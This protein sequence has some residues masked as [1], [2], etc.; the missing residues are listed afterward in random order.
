MEKTVP[1]DEG[2]EAFVEVLNANGVEYIFLNPGTDTFPIQEAL[3]EFKALGK[4]TPEVILCLHESVA[5]A[6]A[7]GY[8]MVTGRP[9]VV[10]IHVDIG[11]LQIGGE[12]HNAQRG[13]IGVVICAG[14]APSTIE[15]NIRGGR[16]MGIHWTQEQ[17]D[18]AGIV[19]G[20]VKWEYELRSNASIHQ[21][22][23]RAFQ[24]A[25]TEPCGPV[26][27]TLP[28]ELL[29]EKIKSVTIPD[30]ARHAAAIT[31]QADPVRLAEVA[32]ILLNA[33]KPIIVAGDTGRNPD[34]VGSLVELAETLGARVM[35]DMER[36]TFPSTHPLCGSGGQQYL[37][38]ADAILLID[39]D[40]PFIPRQ[41]KPKSDAK[42]VHIGIDPIK[43]DIPLWV[44]PADIL[45]QADSSKALPALNALIHRKMTP[46]Q[47]TC[48]KARFKQIQAESEQTREKQ[49][50]AAKAKGSQKPISP[51]WV[52]YCLN[53]VVDEDAIIIQDH[54]A[55]RSLRRTKPGTL[56]AKGGASLGFALGG[57]LGAK[58]AAPDKTV[59]SILG[60]GGFI[61]GSPIATFWAACR[62]QA[63]FLSII[64]NN[65]QYHAVRT[66][67]QGEY[68]K[69][70]YSE[71]TGVWVGMDLAPSPDYAVI[72]Q[73]CGA[74]GR[75]V[76]DPS[77]LLTALKA[78]LDQVRQGKPAV[79]DVRL[80]NPY[81]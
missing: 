43:Q 7:H 72:S 6:A 58:L 78:G 18:Q 48:F 11:T 63:P 57:G 50:A 76:E 52:A 9:Q 47:K 51:D 8:F 20:Y 75:M 30:V 55:M 73:G 3:S 1:V 31:P 70:S 71:K 21:V 39:K 22:V 24:V 69:E 12:L 74:W 32:D 41:T 60:D 44:F 42:I 2:A 4:R 64:L 13:R 27:L 14:R 10:L 15:G 66:S 16:D 49:L 34:A 17:Y 37:K 23:Q 54:G 29:L 79:I 68:G 19:R 40:V 45:I 46:A 62:Y 77:E 35:P 26:Y 65:Q 53:E 33:E 25:S 28:R 36:M 80:E 67:L 56:F 61:F 5:M 81:I 38:E 59:V